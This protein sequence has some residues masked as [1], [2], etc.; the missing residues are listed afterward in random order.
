MGEKSTDVIRELMKLG[1]ITSN[2]GF[3]D[4]DTAELVVS[5]FGH[6]C[7]LV[8]DSTIDSIVESRLLSVKKQHKR[9]AVVTIM[10]HV[11]HGKNIFA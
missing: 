10:G 2:A 6:S 1:I 8:K 9:H 11:D 5:T 4:Q 3:I 7:K